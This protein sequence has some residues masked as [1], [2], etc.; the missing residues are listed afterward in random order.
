[1]KNYITNRSRLCS[2]SHATLP[3]VV[4]FA[5]DLM[6]NLQSQK[7]LLL[8]SLVPE[9]QFNMP[10]HHLLQHQSKPIFDTLSLQTTSCLTTQPLRCVQSEVCWT[11]TSSQG[12]TP[13][14]W[15]LNILDWLVGLPYRHT[16]HWASIQAGETF[17]LILGN[18]N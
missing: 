17:T 12:L 8:K 10:I 1:M 13:I 7:Y 3:L 11:Y 2:S 4:V 9:Q 6:D 14:R 5:E 18:V 16:G 15:P